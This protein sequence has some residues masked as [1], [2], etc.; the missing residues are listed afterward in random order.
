MLGKALAKVRVPQPH[1]HPVNLHSNGTIHIRLPRGHSGTNDAT[2]RSVGNHCENICKS[3]PDRRCNC[4]YVFDSKSAL[5]CSRLP[6][7]QTAILHGAPGSGSMCR[8]QF[9]AAS[10][11]RRGRGEGRRGKRGKLGANRGKSCG[12]CRLNKL[13]AP[14]TGENNYNSICP[15]SKSARKTVNK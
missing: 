3:C 15:M 14:L 13:A 8:R 6:D 10:L 12:N 2:R 4:E 1:S 9:V 7:C 11:T 5:K